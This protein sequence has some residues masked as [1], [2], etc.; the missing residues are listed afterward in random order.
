MHLM[1]INLENFKSFGRKMRIPFNEGFTAITGPNGSGKSNIA[2]AILFVLGP[3]SSKAIRAGKLTDLIFNGAKSKRPAKSCRVS[4]VFNNADRVLPIATDKVTLTRVVKHSPSKKDA[5]YSYFYINGKSSSLN[6]FDNLLA[7]ARISA[8]GYNFVQQGDINRIVG[9]SNLDRRRILDDIAG[10][11]RYDKDIHR[12]EKQREEAE[13]N[14]EKIGILLDEIKRNI[15]ALARD[16]DNAITYREMQGA[17]QLAKA[18]MAQKKR[19]EIEDQLKGVGAQIADYDSERSVFRDAIGENKDKLAELEKELEDVE[20]EIIRV[21]GADAEK[22]K[23]EIDRV[24]LDRFKA[25]DREEKAKE[26]IEEL[27]LAKAAQQQEL[28]GI[29][30]QLNIYK[31][32]VDSYDNDVGVHKKSITDLQAQLEEANDAARETSKDIETLQRDIAQSRKE[33][34]ELLEDQ[35]ALALERDRARDKAERTAVELAQVE[36]TVKTLEFELKDLDFSTSD[37]SKASKAKR[38]RIKELQTAI[39]KEKAAEKKL[40]KEAGELELAVKRLS[41]DF[42]ALKAESEAAVQLQKGYT[43]AVNA[44]IDARD[45]GKLRGVLGTIAELAEVDKKHENALTVAAGMRMQSVVVEDDEAA[46]QCIGYLKKTKIGRATFLPLNKMRKGRPGGKALMAVRND[47]AIGFARDLVKYDDRY[48]AAFWYAFGDTVVVKDLNTARKLMGG[49]RLVT[50]DGELTEASGAM[51]GG[52]I[53]KSMIRFGAPAKTEF[54]RV[55][56]A[57]REAVDR[58]DGVGAE[59]VGLRDR[60]YAA[61]SELRDIAAEEG[62]ESSKLGDL[63]ARRK[64][65][66]GRLKGLRVER[67]KLKSALEKA[68]TEADGRDGDLKGLESKLAELEARRED[69]SKKVTRATPKDLSQRIGE[70][71]EE[72]HEARETLR[73]VE[74]KME[75]VQT[76]YGLMQKHEADVMGKVEE[77][78]GDTKEAKA[79]ISEAKETSRALDVELNGL[80]KVEEQTSSEVE[81]LRTRKERA[82]ESKTKLLGDMDG[83]ETKLETHADLMIQLKVKTQALEAALKEAE[84]ECSRYDVHVKQPLPPLDNLTTTVRDTEVRMA[85]LEPV[86]MRSIDEYDVQVQRRDELQDELKQ[87]EKQKKDLIKLVDELNKKKKYGLYKVFDAIDRNFQEIF[88]TLS[89]GGDAHLQLENPDEPFEG[90]LIIEARPP[91]KKV[92]RLESLSGG[93]KS[94]TALALI[95]AIQ[96]FDPSPFYLLDEVDMFLDAVNAEMVARMVSHNS[97][98]AQVLMIS[99]RKVTLTKADQLYG[100]TLMPTGVSDV[101][102][103]VNLA[104][105]KEEPPPK[106]AKVMA[107]GGVPEDEECA[108]DVWISFDVDEDEERDEAAD[109]P[110]GAVHG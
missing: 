41:R 54:D 19:E 79:I 90:G 92:L 98:Y 69:L 87:L 68:E 50:M 65:Y 45:R 89:N 93:E 26:H 36:E 63:D 40:M 95:F 96:R 100:V 73:D 34:D 33:H 32:E 106:E 110:G 83:L 85:R 48:E 23:G 42:S 15:R 61:E 21:G 109:D 80:L 64:E 107:D 66:R 43:R 60:I 39:F 2:D 11:T 35:H 99:L 71:G 56:K 77:I 13:A 53:A 7:H 84:E 20:K 30:K 97:S 27:K 52:A 51:M 102:G 38:D 94:L 12:A 6:E 91:N 67:K 49:V 105:F 8:D 72:I 4:L 103:K 10:I 5:Y 14:L 70:L 3:K 101:V 57:L 78:E 16:R 28:R 55:R 37:I 62:T 17:L 76:Q 44:V 75:T 9:M 88:A 47:A 46:A 82:F 29:R 81:R 18:Q 108:D 86:N 104:D 25:E 22:L 74:S 31:K 24:R 1:E 58:S 59:L